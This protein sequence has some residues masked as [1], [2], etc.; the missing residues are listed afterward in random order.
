MAFFTS[1][2]HYYRAYLQY[3]RPDY[4][5]NVSRSMDGRACAVTHAACDGR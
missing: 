3:A 2:I 4:D 1:M 5:E